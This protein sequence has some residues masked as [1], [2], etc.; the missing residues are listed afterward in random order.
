MHLPARFACLVLLAL[1]GLAFAQ[2]D[3]T[4]VPL[5]T[6]VKP[7]LPA[8]GATLDKAA[9]EK[10]NGDSKVYAACADAYMKARRATADKYQ[11]VANA[12]ITAANGFA[13]EFNAYASS[14]SAFSKAQAAA[15]PKK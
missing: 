3:D 8:I 14:L 2:V 10:L 6:C 12:Q 13:A 9:A 7:A 11:A 5:P 4:A 1:P 15:Q